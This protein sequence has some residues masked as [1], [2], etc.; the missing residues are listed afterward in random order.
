MCLEK[1]ADEA[2]DTVCLCGM[3]WDVVLFSHMMGFYESAF[4]KQA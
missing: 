1:E 3:M 4:Q 2:E